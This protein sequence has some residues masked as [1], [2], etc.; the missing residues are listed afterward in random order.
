[1][2]GP[3]GMRAAARKALQ[4]RGFP[5]DRIVEESFTSPRRASV[6]DVMQVAT[7]ASAEGPQTFQ[8]QGRVTLLEAALDAGVSISFSCFSGGCGACRIQVTHHAENVVLDEPNDVSAED[9]SRGNV[10]ACL[11]RLRGPVTFTVP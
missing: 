8:V 7:V 5:A 1:L 9:R 4:I 2:C 6:P 11:A 10:P 3:D